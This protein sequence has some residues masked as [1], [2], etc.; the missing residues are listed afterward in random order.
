MARAFVIVAALALTAC[1]PK[2]TRPVP[3][4]IF[5]TVTAA[6][7][8][9]WTTA[10]G[11]TVTYDRFLIDVGHANLN[12]DSCAEYSDARYD[13]IFDGRHQGA[14]KVSESYALGKC[15]FRFRLNSPDDRTLLGTGVSEADKTEMRTPGSDAHAKDRGVS[16]IVAG[17]AVKGNVK[18]TFSWSFR[19]RVGYEDCRITEDDA[20]ISGV[21]LRSGEKL[22]I[23]IAL[24]GEALLLDDLDPD[25]GV[26]RFDPFANADADDDGVITMEELDAVALPSVSVNAGD[27]GVDG[28]TLETFGDYVYEG[29]VPRVARFLGSGECT[30]SQRA[31]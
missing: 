11:W 17:S 9:N 4:S 3:G 5:V 23:D 19:R 14:Q 2:D 7:E 21:V 22:P 18:K 30:L 26:L 6:S 15:S 13:R 27:A 29:L 8:P 12:G 28:G 31:D 1:L 20:T 10:D 24:H 25:V 16:L